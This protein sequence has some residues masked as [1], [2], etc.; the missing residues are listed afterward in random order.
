MTNLSYIDR[1]SIKVITLTSLG[2][3]AIPYW[4][5][6]GG[7]IAGFL[8]VRTIAHA[9]GYFN[10]I[11]YHRWLCHN[12]FQPTVLGKIIMTF[13]MVTSGYGD[14]LRHVIA[15]RLHHPYS[16]TDQDPHSVKILG[17]WGL[18]LARHR[19][20]S[21]SVRIPRDYFKNS[22]A[23]FMHRH[24]WKLYI[25]IN[26][27]IFLL[28]DLKTMLLFCP[29]TFAYG[30]FINTLLNYFGHIDKKTGI[31]APRNMNK[32]FTVLSAGEGLHG[33]HHAHPSSANF[34]GNNRKDPAYPL[35]RLIS[36]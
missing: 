6:A 22:W 15:H 26:I 30:W 32:I 4:F 11:G 14:P 17:F 31:I 25:A 7:T 23:V 24:Y 34:S 35:I 18:W 27:L 21:G 1:A 10:S 20:S 12:S 9:V 3:F 36:C 8:L 5:F 2:L 19:I 29:V 28:F 13:S 33:N 16:D